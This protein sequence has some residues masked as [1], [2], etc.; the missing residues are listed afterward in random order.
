MPIIVKT[1]ARCGTDFSGPRFSTKDRLFCSP[2]CYA[3][4][5]HTV[6]VGAVF[7]R[8]TAI[9]LGTGKRWHCV[10]ECGNTTLTSAQNLNSGKAKSCGCLAREIVSKK[11]TTHGASDTRA[12]NTWSGIIQRC[13]NQNG[14]QWAD[15]GGRGITVCDEWRDFANFLRDMGQP[16][17]GFSIERLDNNAGYNKA[18]CI[19]ADKKTQQRNRRVNRLVTINGD[20]RCVAAWAEVLNVDII[21]VGSRLQRGWSE[22]RA[23][24]LS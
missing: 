2:A 4:S 7:G 18:N 9:S 3:A 24:G 16:P 11:S 10:C 15:Y 19:W 6:S 13:T 5:R 21:L 22:H 20:T 12:H 14:K 23:L 1:C 8:L 17:G